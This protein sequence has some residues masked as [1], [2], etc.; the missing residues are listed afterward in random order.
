MSTNLKRIGEK[1]SRE[2]AL[3]F[4]SLYHHV[5]D[6]DNLRACYD[7]LPRKR[8]VGIDG[9]TNYATTD[10]SDQC[11]RY[12]YYANRI[13]FKWLN[14]KSQRQSYTWDQFRQTLTTLN[15]PAVTVRKDL[16][17]CRRAEAY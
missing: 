10:N 1:A 15:W 7:A 11:E 17:P 5:S 9:V 14:R 13:L 6:V 8:A 16:N 12:V 2:P 3:V 4:T